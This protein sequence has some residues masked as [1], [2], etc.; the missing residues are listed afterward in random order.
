MI[1]P[2]MFAEILDKVATYMEESAKLK[3]KVKSAMIYPAVV[4]GMAVI[5]TS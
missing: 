4:S 2:L 1:D 3:R 5:I